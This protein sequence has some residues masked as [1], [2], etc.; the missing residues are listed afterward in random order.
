MLWRMLVYSD[1]RA[2]NE[3]LVAIGGSISAG[4]ARV[5]A[6]MHA[7]ALADSTMYGR[8]IIEDSLLR[9]PIP[10]EISGRPSFIG[11]YT[12]AWDLARLERALHLAAGARGAL[13]WRF[14]GAFTPGD[15]RFLMYLLAHARTI[16]GLTAVRGPAGL[17]LHAHAARMGY[18]IAAV[19]APNVLCSL[20]LGAWVDRRGR[21]RETLIAT[22]LGR[23]AL[24]ATVPL[25]YA[26][27]WLTIQQLYVVAFLSGTLTVL[28]FVASA[29]FFVAVAPRESYLEA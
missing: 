15:A 23:A 20:H 22:D 6:M 18:L 3:L 25:F 16:G 26:F 24:I 5:N 2:A 8:Y 10:L 13:V 21:R 28:F 11:K 7:L 17:V 4:A 1:D 19:L 27:G 12:T 9:R 29:G 14:R